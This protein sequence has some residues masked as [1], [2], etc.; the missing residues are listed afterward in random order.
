MKKVLLEMREVLEEMGYTGQ[1]MRRLAELA[2]M[3]AR[4][5]REAEPD[6]RIRDGALYLSFMA[7]EN[8]KPRHDER[9][10]EYIG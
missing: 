9:N 1:D 5:M 10:T 3:T 4:F 8:T 7:L 6:R 2:V